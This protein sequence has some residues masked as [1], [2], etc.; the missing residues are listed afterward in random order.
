[1]VVCAGL[2]GAERS[3]GRLLSS[4]W[5]S[6]LCGRF[7]VIHRWRTSG[8]EPNTS[9][10]SEL[11][12]YV[13]PRRLSRQCPCTLLINVDTWESYHDLTTS[14]PGVG[15]PQLHANLSKNASIPDVS[16]GILWADDVNKRFYLYGGES[17]QSQPSSP[18]LLSYDTIY[19]QW[20]SYGAPSQGIQNVAWGAGVGVS[21][22][23]QGFILGGWM[24]NNSIPGWSGAPY[25]TS[26]L[27]MYDMD[28]EAWTNST[29][30]ADNLPRAEGVMVYI[31]ASDTG[32]LIQF[33]GVTVDS[34]GTSEASPMEHINV[35][36]IKSG[37]WYTQT[38][39]GNV[40]P[41]RRKF[42]AGAAWAADRSSYNM[43]VPSYPLPH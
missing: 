22:I 1:M 39:S 27:L 9:E 42:C 17:Y 30:P 35:Y 5:A 3:S 4:L 11:H 15:V 26:S 25:A 21:E 2:S 18:N 24:S 33:G 16:G 34:N 41:T 40:P 29:G 8:L 38:A 31:P 14:P 20:D 6:N 43:Y 23:G 36:D 28:N 10:P 37:K 32:L 13:N 12:Q 19:D 7:E